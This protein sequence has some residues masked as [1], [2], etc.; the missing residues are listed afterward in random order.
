MKIFF[1]EECLLHNP[2]YEILSGKI[3]TYYETP[4]RLLEIRRALEGDDI[5]QIENAD[6][7]IDV[8]GHALQV[9]SVNYIE[10][11]ESA[12]KLW[13][14]GGGDPKDPIFPDVFPNPRFTQ[15]FT[16]AN[17]A[18][19]SLT[20]KAGYYCFDLSCPITAGSLRFFVFACRMASL[21]G[22]RYVHFCASLCQG[23]S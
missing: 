4:N 1:D 9:H 19:R 12:F 13:V 18:P 3:V 21:R 15:R 10:Y 16:T 22:F 2:P 23:L 5:F 8:Q 7:S 20:G 17:L 6:R 14:E 11:L